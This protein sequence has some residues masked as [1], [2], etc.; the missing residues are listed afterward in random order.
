MAA[1]RE[2]YEKEFSHKGALEK[3]LSDEQIPLLPE[4]V[5]QYGE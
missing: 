5:Q 1:N 2:I 4:Q 3:I